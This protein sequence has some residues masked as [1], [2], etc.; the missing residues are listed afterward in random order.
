MGPRGTNSASI[1]TVISRGLIDDGEDPTWSTR[2]EIA[3]VRIE[4]EF[5][6][7]RAPAIY[8]IRPDCDGTAPDARGGLAR[9]VARRKQAR[10]H[11]LRETT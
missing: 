5:T 4:G 7:N 2:N 6:A 10:V 8:T 3:F 9:L 1:T 11:N